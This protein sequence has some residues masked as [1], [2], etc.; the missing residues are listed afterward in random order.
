MKS[1]KP[2]CQKCGTCCQ[3]NSPALHLQDL[4]LI[5]SGHIAKN[6]LI[7]YRKGEW[8]YDNVAET[9]IQLDQEIIKPA[10]K[11]YCIFYRHETRSCIIYNNRPLECQ[12]QLCS[13][14]APLTKMYQKD[15]L[16][17]QNILSPESPLLELIEYHEKNCSLR[18]L[19]Q[20]SK[21]LTNSIKKE[22]KKMIQFEYH[23]RYTLYQQT[24][25]QQSDMFFLLGR[26]IEF[27]LKQ[28]RLAL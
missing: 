19:P 6:Q 16:T 22:L 5:T 4:P 13:D 1:N 10:M 25:L 28:S 23:F 8:M 7:T 21:G 18:D 24:G 26:P 14:P 15:R 17:R 2:I 12:V 20:S 9:L 27:I 3:K 11:K